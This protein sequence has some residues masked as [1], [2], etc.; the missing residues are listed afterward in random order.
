MNSKTLF[1]KGKA[2][3]ILLWGAIILI[4]ILIFVFTRG[5]M[6]KEKD[7]PYGPGTPATETVDSVPVESELQLNN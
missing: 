3:I 2:R 4:V 5:F 1:F 7:A 6:S